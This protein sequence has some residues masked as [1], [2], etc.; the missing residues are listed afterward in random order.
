M[1]K[2]LLMYARITWTLVILFAGLYTGYVAVRLTA[3]APRSMEHR[4]AFLVLLW[5]LSAWLVV[6]GA[7]RIWL[8]HKRAR[9]Q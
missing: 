5:L 1:K 9:K 7:R 8:L 2:T 6:E 3:E 4:G